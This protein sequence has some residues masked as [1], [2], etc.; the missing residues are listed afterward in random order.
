MRI[1]I[2][3]L[4]NDGKLVQCLQESFSRGFISFEES[5][6]DKEKVEEYNFLEFKLAFECPFCGCEMRETPKEFYRCYERDHKIEHENIDYDKGYRLKTCKIEDFKGYKIRIHKSPEIV[7]KKEYNGGR[8]K[9]IVFTNNLNSE[10]KFMDRS[11]SMIKFPL[12]KIQIFQKDSYEEVF[13][14]LIKELRNKRKRLIDWNSVSGDE[15]QELFERLLIRNNKFET[16]R[17]GGES[18]DR[19]VDGYIRHKDKDLDLMVQCKRNTSKSLSRRD[20]RDMREDAEDENLKGFV[21]GCITI[22]GD[23][24]APSRDYSNENIDYVDIWQETEIKEELSKYPDLIKE[25]FF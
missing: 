3:E 16:I 25:Y 7:R 12:E 18:T 1:S 23:A 2:Q 15:F 10:F 21:L 19:G 9:F 14:K 22:S 17:T 5:Y 11:G 24:A 6:I 13:E 20:I 8:D 4:T